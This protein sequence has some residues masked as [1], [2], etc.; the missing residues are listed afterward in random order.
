MR[1]PRTG[2]TTAAAL[3]L[4]TSLITGCD[5]DEED[6]AAPAVAT[7]SSPAAAATG[8]AAKVVITDAARQEAEKV[9]T[10]RCV[11]CHGPNGEGNGP[12]AA[13]L[14]PKPRNYHDAKWQATVSDE[15]IEKTIVYGGAAVGKSPQMVP[16]PDL[17]SKPE[18]VA[19]LREKIRIFGKTPA[20]EPTK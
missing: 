6:E 12:G 19:A 5:S 14:E 1:F 15:S 3:V 20:G 18:V 13:K 8:G 10:S 16:N 11:T 9:F 7:A 17:G 2:M 4:A